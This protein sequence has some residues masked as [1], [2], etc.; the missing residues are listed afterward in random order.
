M[1]NKRKVSKKGRPGG[2]YNRPV[3]KAPGKKDKK[4]K[5]PPDTIR[6]NKYI[7]STGLCSRREADEYIRT[8]LIMV[9]NKVVTELGTRINLSDNVKYNGEKLKKEKNVYILMNKPKE[10]I[11][12]VDDPHAKRIVIDLIGN[13]CKERIYPVGRLDKNTTGVLLITNDGELT[14]KLLHPSSKV[15]KIYRVHV[16][17][18]LKNS[19][20][21]KIIEGITLDDGFIKVDAIHYVGN[22]KKQ[23]GIEIHSG[24]NRIIRRIFEKLNYR[25]TK[26]DRVVFAGL[27]KKGLSRGKWRYLTNKE[28]ALLK[29]GVFK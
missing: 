20:M 17:K 29:M 23:V 18:T 24:R 27:T 4:F 1:H 13:T 15:K 21:Q 12:T 6:L 16:N 19:D 22:D 3:R 9:N 26:L 11:T 10:Y 5:N 25:V 14:Q 8:G 2:S 7:A 28:I